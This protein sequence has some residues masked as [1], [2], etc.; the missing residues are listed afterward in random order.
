MSDELTIILH[1]DEGIS[2]NVNNDPLVLVATLGGNTMESD[3]VIPG[4]STV[5]DCNLVWETNKK[6]VK[7]MKMENYPIKIE[8]FAV[9]SEKDPSQRKLIGHL[10]F[11]VRNIPF[12]PPTKALTYK[13]K[14][15]K[16]I[17]LASEWR[18]LKPEIMLSLMITDKEFF[19][20]TRTALMTPNRSVDHEFLGDVTPKYDILTS[21][22]GIFIRLLKEEG[23]LQVGNIDTDCDVFLAKI[24]LKNVV[25]AESM[26]ST[27][28]KAEID[29]NKFQLRYIF[30]QNDVPFVCEMKKREDGTYGLQEII[31]INIRTSLQVLQ[32]YFN[33]I[34]CI[35]FQIFYDDKLIGNGKLSLANLLQIDNL[36]EFLTNC[37]DNENTY[38]QESSCPVI[39]SEEISPFIEKP[40]V[41]FRFMLSYISTNKLATQDLFESR[42]EKEDLKLPELDID[43]G[44]DF[45]PLESSFELPRTP[46]PLKLEHVGDTPGIII[47]PKPIME[48]IPSE[49]PESIKAGSIA[50]KNFEAEAKKDQIP[51]TFSYT[52]VLKNIKFTNRVENGIWQVSFYH[53]RAETPFTIINLELQ[54]IEDE[55]VDF[56]DLELQLIFSAIPSDVDAIIKAD[57]CLF[58]IS[59][60]RGTRG[61][62]ELNSETL[63]MGEKKSP[64]TILLENQNGE[65]MAMATIFV[66][67]EDLGINHNSQVKKPLPMMP[68]GANP[69]SYVDEGLAYR[70]VEDLEKWKKTQEE[71]FLVELKRKEIQHLAKLTAEWKRKKSKMEK[72]MKEKMEKCV[73]LQ[74]TLEDAQKSLKSKSD[75]QSQQE[76][77][78]FQAKSDLEQCFNK[79][80]L[81]IREKARRL[82]DDME[83]KLHYE[84]IKYKELELST[85]ALEKENDRLRS[86][87]AALEKEA[88]KMKENLF[89]KEQLVTLFQDMRL[90]NERYENA[91]KSKM[92]YKE[93]WAKLI[94]E[95]HMLKSSSTE[96]FKD[97]VMNRKAFDIDNWL[98]NEKFDLDSDASEMDFIK[99]SFECD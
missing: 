13:S 54:N 36:T 69:K 65:K 71:N 5:F 33:Q 39:P 76:R 38:E 88:S 70:F 40:S 22:Q 14:W 32:K 98:E 51:H 68:V 90:L 94:R 1:V 41:S 6:S 67:I 45:A 84:Q 21:Q 93:Q 75:E 77:N 11:P 97:D 12:L 4:H 63:L 86:R 55:S 56:D 99:R 74:K 62:A 49:K 31:A 29:K 42:K 23:V 18:V 47:S 81:E 80:L 20:R 7:R 96:Q 44:G 95:V 19:S 2:L 16:L 10:I 57:N 52:L 72:D 60:P 64:G 26:V 27:M 9:K 48:E 15:Y 89:P 35:P 37:H 53:P 91:Q 87:I 50:S 25:H 34:F 17:G 92:Y 46:T 78:L 79:K 66:Y 30:P 85:K 8:V 3:P 24:L 61:K 73:A 59:G 58:N 82:E 43:A 83:R 28:E